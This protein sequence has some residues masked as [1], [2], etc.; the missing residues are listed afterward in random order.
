MGEKSI[1]LHKFSF[2]FSLDVSYWIL[3]TLH[4]QNSVGGE[5]DGMELERKKGLH[6][7]CQCVEMGSVK[8]DALSFAMIILATAMMN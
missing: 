6:I 2:G 4:V 7:G 5:K 8:H 1:K 3:S